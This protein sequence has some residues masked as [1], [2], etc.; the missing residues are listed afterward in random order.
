MKITKSIDLIYQYKYTI[1]LIPLLKKK[2][3]TPSKIKEFMNKNKTEP[4]LIYQLMIY[5]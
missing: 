5:E 4:Y 2:F 1:S 3:D